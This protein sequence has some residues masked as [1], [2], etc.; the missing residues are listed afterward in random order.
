V[1][2]GLLVAVVGAGDLAPPGAVAEVV[3]GDA[4][5]G[6]LALHDVDRAGVGRGPGGCGGSGAGRV[7]RGS[8]VEGG[9]GAGHGD[10]GA[11]RGG[12]RCGGVGAAGQHDQGQDG[13]DESADELLLD[14]ESREVG[15]ADAAQLCGDFQDE[16]DGEGGPGEPAD[17]GEAGDEDAAVGVGLA[18][19]GTEVVEGG[20]DLQ[21]V[22]GDREE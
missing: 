4:P 7:G 15:G 1:A 22:G 14:A 5:E 2:V 11:E 21:R 18:D 16:G 20:Q 19:G 17:P 12:R 13:C 3:F 8:G 6:V 9:G 10:G